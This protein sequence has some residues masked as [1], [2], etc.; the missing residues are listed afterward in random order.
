MTDIISI[1]LEEHQQQKDLCHN[2]QQ[3]TDD[4]EKQA[5]IYQLVHDCIVHEG[6]EEQ[7]LYPA[8][9]K[10]L[11]DGNHLVEHG[12][13]E[14]EKMTQLLQ[15]LEHMQPTDSKYLET[16]QKFVKKLNHHTEDEESWL[17]E[18]LRPLLADEELKFLGESFLKA[19]DVVPTRPHTWAP[20]TY[21]LNLINNV[22]IAPLDKL[23]DSYRFE[24][25]DES[26]QK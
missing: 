17:T 3:A 25:Q 12:T 21:P 11:P 14:H 20:D 7:I 23:K 13:H 2:F 18:K 26:K 15:E 19:K 10:L 22:V 4:K 9:K 8:L 6:C 1:V 24:N 5:I 16:A